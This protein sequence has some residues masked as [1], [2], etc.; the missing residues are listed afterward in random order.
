MTVLGWKDEDEVEGLPVGPA[1]ILKDSG[2][3]EEKLGWVSKPEAIAMAKDSGY[4]F[5]EL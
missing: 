1:F 3:I 5:E 2:E 4:D